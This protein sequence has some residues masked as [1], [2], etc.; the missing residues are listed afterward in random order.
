MRSYVIHQS[1]QSLGA[2]APEDAFIGQLRA[3]EQQPDWLQEA[4]PAGLLAGFEGAPRW[5][6]WPH[7][8][9]VVL[10]GDSAGTVDPTFGC[11]LSMVARD[12]RVLSDALDDGDDWAAAAEHY[13]GERVERY[14][15]QLRVEAWLR[16][17]LFTPG[18]GNFRPTLT[19]LLSE[20]PRRS[21]RRPVRVSR[22]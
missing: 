15:A 21:A 18:A 13:A 1:G 14:R 17:I 5:V 19:L 6:R 22:P 20:A 4:R 2:G 16:S 11:G 9:G 10:L 8:R 7:C 12:A 3:F